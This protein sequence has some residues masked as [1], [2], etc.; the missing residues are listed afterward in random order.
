MELKEKE[1]LKNKEDEEKERLA[2][3]FALKNMKPGEIMK[4]PEH[5]IIEFAIFLDPRS[6][7][8]LSFTC[9][10]F[11]QIIIENS[12]SS[13]FKKFCRAFYKDTPPLPLHTIFWTIENL[14]AE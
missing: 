3:E 10:N 2:L 4:M 1:I 6:L 7:F 9:K 12:N 5:F 13:I 11:R 14:V 8:K